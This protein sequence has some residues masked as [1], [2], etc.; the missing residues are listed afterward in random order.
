MQPSLYQFF[1][2]GTGQHHLFGKEKWADFAHMWPNAHAP[3]ET[4][5]GPDA[6]QGGDD[7]MTSRGRRNTARSETD[8]HAPPDKLNAVNGI[9]LTVYHIKDEIDTFT[10]DRTIYLLQNTNA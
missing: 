9:A 1:P 8:C 4:A 10:L 3:G 2:S 7:K 6:G 5:E